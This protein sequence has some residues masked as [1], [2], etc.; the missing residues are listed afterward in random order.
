M[1]E[2]TLI[3]RFYSMLSSGEDV[4]FAYRKRTGEL[5]IARGTTHMDRIPEE[6]RPKGTGSSSSIVKP[7]WDLNVS[8]WRA[9]D[10]AQIAWVSHLCADNLTIAEQD[11][12][13]T[14]KTE[15]GL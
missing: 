5:R 3:D 13:N 9:F 10:P 1:L 7:Y 8:G 2:Q 6:N 11:A 15:H 12:I 4:H 14:Y